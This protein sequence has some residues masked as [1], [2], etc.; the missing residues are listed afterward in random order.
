MLISFV[1]GYY[2]EKNILQDVLGA[3]ILAE[4]KIT[5]ERIIKVRE[6]K[7]LYCDLENSLYWLVDEKKTV[8]KVK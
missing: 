4:K 5:F 8:K 2:G 3:K 7:V 1:Y 6:N